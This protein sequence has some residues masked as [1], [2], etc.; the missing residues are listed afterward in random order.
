MNYALIENDVVKNII[1]LRPEN[2]KDFPQAVPFNDLPINIGDT[3]KDN[4]FYHNGELVQS[5]AEVLLIENEQA[6]A[7]IAELDAA[8]LNSTYEN[9]IGGLE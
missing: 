6:E 2:I 3:Y 5:F 8:L 9:I 7:T 1:W 4:R